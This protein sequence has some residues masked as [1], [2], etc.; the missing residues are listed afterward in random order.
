M[1]FD[2]MWSTMITTLLLVGSALGLGG[3]FLIRGIIFVIHHLHWI[4]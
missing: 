1:N 2:G 3:Y 4:A